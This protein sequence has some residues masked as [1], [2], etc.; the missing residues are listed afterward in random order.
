MMM[1]RLLLVLFSTLT[2]AASAQTEAA[3]PDSVSPQAA[4]T[5]VQ[6]APALRYAYLSYDSVFCAMPDYA[7]AQHNLDQLRAQYDAEAK[8]TEDEF[9]KKY[10]EFLDGQNE[11]PQTILQKRQTELQELMDKNIQFKDESKRLLA[12]AEQ[13]AYAPLHAKLTAVLRR[14]GTERH[15]AFILNTDNRAVPFLNPEMGDDITLYVKSQLRR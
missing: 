1:Q 11:F 2:L 15:Y 12:Q 9:N 7:I 5:V 13:T 4:V 3:K 10:E 14:I 8:R 6:T